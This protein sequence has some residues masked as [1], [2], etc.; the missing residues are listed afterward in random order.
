MR[1]IYIHCNGG[2]GNRFNSLIVG[3]LVAHVGNFEPMIL[4]P[5]NNWCRSY[6]QRLFK[7]KFPVTPKGLEYVS[8]R[9]HDF[10]FY[11]HCMDDIP[12]ATATHPDKFG[13]LQGLLDNIGLT[14]KDVVYNHDCIPK[15]ASAD[16]R[17][18]EIIKGLEFQDEI[19][20]KADAFLEDHPAGL[21][22]LHLRNT[23]FGQNLSTFDELENTVKTNVDTQ[24]FIC[25]D[26]KELEER[27]TAYANAFAYPK[28]AYVQK[29][30]EG[31]AWRTDFTHNGKRY[32]FN[33]ERSDES[34][35]EALVDLII[36]SRCNIVHTSNSS[37]LKTAKLFQNS[38]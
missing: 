16:Y 34:V 8:N 38:R 31:I 6:F 27:F 33:V 36:M 13:S 21:T 35:K 30:V 7:N 37:F 11:S 28:T 24:Y 4:W 10:T 9:V 17:L 20:E 22:A 32:S 19:R 26:D 29:M 15:W 14:D 1:K 23:D 18:N 2:F 12:N 25:S 5:T 3:L